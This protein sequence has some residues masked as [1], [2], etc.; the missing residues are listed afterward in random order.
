MKLHLLREPKQRKLPF[1][2]HS[3]RQK[4]TNGVA[5]S[6]AEPIDELRAAPVP[7]DAAGAAGR[8]PTP[9]DAE[10]V[11]LKAKAWQP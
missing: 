8:I 10:L 6:I 4:V 5:A 1:S 2:P 7:E 9:S 3:H 11:D